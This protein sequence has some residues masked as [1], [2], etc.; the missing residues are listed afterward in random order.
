MTRREEDA[1]FFRQR[2]KDQQAL[3]KERLELGYRRHGFKELSGHQVGP[4]RECGLRSE[5]LKSEAG[6]MFVASV[7]RMRDLRSNWG[8]GALEKLHQKIFSLDAPYVEG[9]RKFLGFLRIDTDRVWTS[10]DECRSFYRLLTHDGKLAC[11]PHFLVGLKLRDGRFVRPHAIWMLPRGA[12]IWNEPG[13]EG[14]RRGPVDLFHSVYFGLNNALLE[15]GADAGAPAAS[16]QV[17]CPL[18]PEWHTVCPQD[19]HFPDLAEHAEYLELNHNRETLLRRAAS[20]QS[21]MGI[22]ESNEIFNFCQKTAYAVLNGWHFSADGEFRTARQ[23][24]RSGAIVDRLHQELERA[25]AASIKQ[26]GRNGAEN[27]SL[28]VAKVAEYAVAHWNPDVLQQ[29]K[30]NRGVLMHVVGGRK[31]LKERQFIAARYSAQKNAE[32]TLN[33]IEDAIRR[34]LEKGIDLSK[35][36]I[37]RESGISRPTINKYW[38]ELAIK[39]GCGEK[40]RNSGSV[41]ELD[42]SGDVKNGVLIKSMEAPGVASQYPHNDERRRTMAVQTSMSG[43]RPISLRSNGR[44]QD[45]RVVSYVS[46]SVESS[47]D[48]VHETFDNH[49]GGHDRDSLISENGQKAPKE[50]EIVTER[51]CVPET[52]NHAGNGIASAPASRVM[53]PP[54]PKD[55]ACRAMVPTTLTTMRAASIADSPSISDG[56]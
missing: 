4:V 16:Q 23:N 15:A 29:T 51:V 56:G 27:T 46:T 19:S 18:S 43:P 10:V 37:A 28:I 9:N 50:G 22:F 52:E 26:S 49:S 31:T 8:K 36:N 5:T 1:E 39:I 24:G 3:V 17:K 45:E 42:E 21:G 6:R 12:A 53:V 20:V 13:K 32:R 30:K 33:R 7:P 44:D 40:A 38:P 54:M 25:L 55:Q 11:E 34:L 41:N 48:I 14:W 35:A 47:P 2:Y